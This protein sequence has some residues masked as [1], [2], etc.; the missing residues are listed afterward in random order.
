[1]SRVF[2]RPRLLVAVS[3]LMVLSL[4][5]M[6][7]FGSS[8]VEFSSSLDLDDS[9]RGIGIDYDTVLKLDLLLSEDS[10]AAFAGAELAA[11]KQF[12]SAGAQKTQAARIERQQARVMNALPSE[13]QVL[14][15]Y[16]LG[17]NAVRVSVPM[18]ALP[19]L[20]GI[21][22]IERFS[23]VGVYTVNNETSVSWIGAPEVW[24]AVGDGSGITIGIIDTGIDYYHA[25]FGGSGDPADY[26]ADDPTI[27]E[28]GSFPTVKVAGGYD[29]SGDFY[30][31]SGDAY[32]DTPSPDDDPRDCQGHGSHVA[33]TAA[34]Q[35]VD[36]EI[37]AGVAK[38][39]TLYALK[40][41]GCDGSTTLTADAI[42]WS[43]D[44]N[45]DGDLSDHLD[46]I[47]M[48]LGAPF[49]TPYDASAAAADNAAAM[50][51]IVVASA[52]NSGNVPYV[53]GTPGSGPGVISVAS[54]IDGGYSVLGI[55]VDIDGEVSQ[56]EAG[57]AAFGPSLEE[58]EPVS[59]PVA[60]TT[61]SKACDPITEDLTGLIALISRGDCAF[62]DKVKNAQARGAVGV[63]VHNNGPGGPITMG[64]SDASIEIPSVFITLADG[65][66]MRSAIANTLPVAATLSSDVIIL[67]PELADTLS[68]FTSRGP[69][70][71]GS[72]FKPD[73]SAPGQSILSTEVGT[74]TG[75]SLSSGTSMAAPHV[76]GMAA[77]LRQQHPDLSVDAIKSIVMN[78]VAPT[79]GSYPITLQ[80][81]GVVRADSAMELGAYTT[82]AGVSFGRLNPLA[83]HVESRSVTV[84]NMDTEDKTYA[85]STA[86][87]Q[88]VPGVSLVAPDSVFVAGGGSATFGIE[89]HLDPTLMPSDDA[90]LSQREADGRLLLTAA[91]ESLTV[92]WMAVV[93]PASDL[94]SSVLSGPGKDTYIGVSNSGPG[95]AVG[96][97]FTLSS[98]GPLG[99]IGVRTF[100]PFDLVQ[101]GVAAA[102]AW[103]S[104]TVVETDVFLD[105]DQDGIPEWVLVSFDLGILTGGPV[106][107][108]PITALIGLAG[109]GAT[110]QWFVDADMNDGVH[111]LTVDR[112]GPFGFLAEDDMAFDYLAVTYDLTGDVIGFSGGSVDLERLQVPFLSVGM[113]SGES[114]AVAVVEPTTRRGAAAGT[115][116]SDY[117]LMLYPTNVV[118]DQYEV[119][120]VEPSAKGQ[121]K[122][123]PKFD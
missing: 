86:Y 84:T 67:K 58:I 51:V 64:G 73:V 110:L 34:G 72:T 78:S 46:V 45:G 7:A 62:V 40:V 37:G 81:T 41:F 61:P 17:A 50:G 101:F 113:P 27:V 122:S 56:Y 57:V 47:N 75:G 92:G 42:E 112:S 25:N 53:T 108:R 82:P 60:V 71:G 19:E 35:G 8:G 91:D 95:D 22:G 29:F 3:L 49:G 12:P 103:E 88:T 85:I 99:A 39:A 2:T 36:G 90:F 48:S 52:G 89:L 18:A 116:A 66:T 70:H 23:R 26:E 21:A 65:E 28:E 123:H 38:G 54:S 68:S 111:I 33:G 77:L 1:M 80:G 118:G 69:G 107:G 74:G 97:A 114:G 83:A 117:L 13:V 31:A 115:E 15:T 63:I 55:A 87:H 16:S 109:Q 14:G 24:E 98:E 32:P 96:H 105:A 30:D 5:A 76:A 100:E 102:S 106:D 4:L 9:M 44:P 93:D 121:K 104:A 120:R 119:V 94:S 79:P 6:P 43:L 59:A 20:F 10:V 11:G